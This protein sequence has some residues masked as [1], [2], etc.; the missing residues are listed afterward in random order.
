MKKRKED[1]ISIW[2]YYIAW[3]IGIFAAIVLLYGII[4]ALMG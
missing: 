1:R 2:L 3:A 4:R